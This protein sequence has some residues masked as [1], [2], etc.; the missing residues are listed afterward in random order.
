MAETFIFW[1]FLFALLNYSYLSFDLGHIKL[2]SVIIIL[3]NVNFYTVIVV[4]C[5]GFH[6][7]GFLQMT[8][9]SI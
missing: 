4:F 6:K 2:T 7:N 1:G 5:F 3:P 9:R 8:L